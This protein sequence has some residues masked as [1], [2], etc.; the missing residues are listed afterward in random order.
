MIM[1]F[2]VSYLVQDE[3]VGGFLAFSPLSPRAAAPSSHR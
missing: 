1:V 3:V 2:L